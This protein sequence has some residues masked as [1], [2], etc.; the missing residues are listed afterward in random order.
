MLRKEQ[1][2][3]LPKAGA[4][5][6]FRQAV[7]FATFCPLSVFTYGRINSLAKARTFG[8]DDVLSPQA[9]SFTPS[10]GTV[11]RARERQDLRAQSFPRPYSA[12]Q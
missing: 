1:E 11:V 12:R 5:L 7:A 6:T 8:H 9:L 2:R 3:L 4:N 10:M